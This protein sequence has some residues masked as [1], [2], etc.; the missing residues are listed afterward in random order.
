MARLSISFAAFL[1]TAFTGAVPVAA[2]V[3]NF[4][5]QAAGRAGSFTGTSDSPFTIGSA[6]FNGGELLN[7]E[8][9]LDAD[10]TGIYASQGLFGSSETNPLIISFA[11]PVN[12]FSVLLVN[13]DDMR[14][15]TVS[16]DLGNS[17]TMPVASAGA[18]GAAVF[19]L[20]GQGLQKVYISS[21]NTDAWDFA[22]DN[23]SFTPVAST[24]EPESWLLVGAPFAL[25]IFFR[26]RRAST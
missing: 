2:T 16:D 9:G 11:S 15:Y 20:P 22:I 6:I 7:A 12:A 21:A 5:A 23:V 17:I 13:G 19:S 4:E 1:L 8:I 14:S 18:L 10:R 26:R 24:P 25:L 3:I